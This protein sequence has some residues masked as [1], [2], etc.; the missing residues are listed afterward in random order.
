M[1][2]AHALEQGG[3]PL[4][5]A[6]LAPQRKGHVLDGVQ[7]RE[8]RVVLE[9]VAY[10]APTRGQVGHASRPVTPEQ[11]ALVEHDLAGVGR[12]Q[13]GNG[14]QGHGLAR[15]RRPEQHEYLGTHIQ[16][17]LEAE[18]VEP[19]L[20]VD[21]ESHVA[22]H[23]VTPRRRTAHRLTKARAVISATIQFAT[24]YSRRCTAS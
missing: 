21:V 18:R 13:P 9:H 6:L 11:H 23:R 12:H 4:S 20:D 8:E 7:V 24:P 10:P 19:L 14:L 22:V 15:A 16:A 17:H 5:A 1:L 2:E 3:G